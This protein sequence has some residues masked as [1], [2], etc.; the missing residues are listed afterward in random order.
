[1]SAHVRSTVLVE[2]DRGFIFSPIGL[3]DKA[4]TNEVLS[5]LVGS[6]W[7]CVC[8]FYSNRSTNY[9]YPVQVTSI[10]LPQWP[11]LNQCNEPIH[12]CTFF[13]S[14]AGEA[15]VSLQ[16]YYSIRTTKT[17]VSVYVERAYWWNMDGGK[18]GQTGQWMMVTGLYKT[19][20]K[21]RKG[22]NT[23][24][25]PKVSPRRRQQNIFWTLWLQMKKEQQKARVCVEPEA[26]NIY[27]IC[28]EICCFDFDTCSNNPTRSLSP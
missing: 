22:G 15:H 12:T 4:I 7:M 17:F 8:E 13:I 26:V 10:L 1:M 18:R 19:Q 2:S 11:E 24:E 25:R 3:S 9:C 5:G 20:A 27:R 14:F 28:C 23:K 6:T 21:K 16:I